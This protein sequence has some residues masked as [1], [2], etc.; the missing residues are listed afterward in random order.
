MGLDIYTFIF[1]PWFWLCLTILF[2]VIEVLCSFTLVTVWFAVSSLIMI[3]V[4]VLTKSLSVNIRF[5]LH[6]GIFFVIAIVLL[7]FTRPLAVK[8][9]RIGVEKTNV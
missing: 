7:L 5:G 3:F 2:T 4:P 1:S 8:K 9:L 6:I